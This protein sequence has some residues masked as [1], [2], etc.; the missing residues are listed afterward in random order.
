MKFRLQVIDGQPRAVFPKEDLRCGELLSRLLVPSPYH[1][2]ILLWEVI[3]VEQKRA[4]GW[5]FDDSTIRLICT[6]ESLVI[7]E[8]VRSVTDRAE[9]PQVGLSLKE[10]KRLLWRWR[11]EHVRWEFQCRQGEAEI[12]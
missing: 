10:A 9:P 11:F 5:I 12:G 3:R 6:P 2:T 8:S 7:T 4:E 1:I